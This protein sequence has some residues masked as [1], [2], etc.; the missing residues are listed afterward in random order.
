MLS[1]PVARRRTFGQY[2]TPQSV[3][4]LA[5]AA[6]V[7]SETQSVIDPMCG[8]GAMLVAVGDRLSY[9]DVPEARVHG[10]EMDPSVPVSVHPHV[11]TRVLTDDLFQLM[12]GSGSGV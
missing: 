6:A 10:V 12:A 7:T 5:C 4:A 2:F 1:D 3:S 9:L 8:T 11:A